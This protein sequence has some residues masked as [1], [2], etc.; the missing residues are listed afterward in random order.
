MFRVSGLGLYYSDSYRDFV[1]PS[2]KNMGR[3]GVPESF[4]YSQRVEVW[5]IRYK[6]SRVMGF[7][8]LVYKT[9]VLHPWCSYF[10]RKALRHLGY[11]RDSQP[12]VSGLGFCEKGL[13]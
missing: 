2:A 3:V 5:V 10:S 6:C 11:Q 7:T 13:E 8:Y 9:S 12:F 1:C 4:H